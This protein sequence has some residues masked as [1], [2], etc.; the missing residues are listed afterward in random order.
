[1]SLRAS[2]R[3]HSAVTQKNEDSEL[4]CYYCC[5]GRVEKI[6]EK[7][8][9]LPPF[10]SQNPFSSDAGLQKARVQK[11]VEALSVIGSDVAPHLV[12]EEHLF[13][14]SEKQQQCL[15]GISLSAIFRLGNHDACAR[16]A[17]DGLIIKE[18][19]GSYGFAFLQRG[20]HEAKL[21]GLE[22]VGPRIAD[23]LSK[24]TF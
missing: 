4:V 12:H 11:E 17:K 18:I 15:A 3:H 20:N 16:P 19:D 7:Y 14:V 9:V 24:R 23:K 1:M 2:H 21:A 6:L 22:D 8:F 5:Q 13:A 10:R